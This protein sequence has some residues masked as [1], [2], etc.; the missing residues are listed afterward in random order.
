MRAGYC[1]SQISVLDALL[2]LNNAPD[3]L[4]YFCT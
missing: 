3:E 1:V 4:I 2:A